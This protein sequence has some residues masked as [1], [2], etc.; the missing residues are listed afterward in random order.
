MR[1]LYLI[2]R[3]INGWYQE[4]HACSSSAAIREG[5]FSAYMVLPSFEFFCQDG[6]GANGW[7]IFLIVSSSDICIL[8][9]FLM[10]LTCLERLIQNSLKSRAEPGMFPLC[11][12][13]PHFFYCVLFCATWLLYASDLTFCWEFKS[14]FECQLKNEVLLGLLGP[15]HLELWFISDMPWFMQWCYFIWL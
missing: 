15:R 8:H 7:R 5:L 12:C 13:F 9:Q 11:V 4:L 6:P 3:L 10:F 1:S 2:Y 14:L